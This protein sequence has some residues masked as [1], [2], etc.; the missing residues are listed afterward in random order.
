MQLFSASVTSRV[1]KLSRKT[2][3]TVLLPMLRSEVRS[4]SQP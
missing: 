3:L 1:A 4:C 2:L